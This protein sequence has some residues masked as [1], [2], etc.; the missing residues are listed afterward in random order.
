[1]ASH[2]TST[3]PQAH[4]VVGGGRVEGCRCR[5]DILVA[6]PSRHATQRDGMAPAPHSAGKPAETSSALILENALCTLDA[7]V[8]AFVEKKIVL[9][10]DRRPARIIGRVPIGNRRLLPR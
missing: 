9:A 8:A 5:R 1:L 2:G 6:P 4:A 3:G 10:P 7:L